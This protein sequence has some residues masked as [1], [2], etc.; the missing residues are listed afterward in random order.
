MRCWI[1]FLAGW[2]HLNERN[3]NHLWAIRGQDEYG[4]QDRN[5][6]RNHA[7]REYCHQSIPRPVIVERPEGMEGRD[8]EQKVCER[9]D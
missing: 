3:D 1:E 4:M 7:C 5:N 6:G 2:A 8:Q 9:V